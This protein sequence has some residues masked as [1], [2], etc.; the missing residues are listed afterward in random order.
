MNKKDIVKEAAILSGEPVRRVQAIVY[1]YEQAI[2]NAVSKDTEENIYI[3]RIGKL[4]P[5]MIKGR[6][7]VL[8]GVEGVSEDKKTVRFKASKHLISAVK[9]ETQCI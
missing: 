8:K 3:G 6:K 4:V 1:A 9:G 7:Y 5:S 2:L